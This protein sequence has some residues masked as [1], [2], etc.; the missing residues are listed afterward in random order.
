M[1]PPD[2][3]VSLPWTHSNVS[4]G[5]LRMCP[6]DTLGYTYLPD[7][8]DGFKIAPYYGSLSF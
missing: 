5:H 7:N 3:Y 8:K 6:R 4:T 2:T 1:C